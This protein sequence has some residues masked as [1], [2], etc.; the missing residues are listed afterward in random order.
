MYALESSRWIFI[1][2]TDMIINKPPFTIQQREPLCYSPQ[3]GITSRRLHLTLFSPP[4]PPSQDPQI[5]HL[6][7]TPT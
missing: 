3:I 1:T 2:I 6:C 5:S 7:V 4:K